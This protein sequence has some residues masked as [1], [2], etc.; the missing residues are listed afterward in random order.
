M[1]QINVKVGET[2]SV[3]QLPQ[4]LR[5]HYTD[6]ST[7]DIPIDWDMEKLNAID[8][9]KEGTYTV[10]GQAAVK[11]Y[12]FPSIHDR[13][14]PAAIKFD[15]KYYFIATRDNGQQTVL[16]WVFSRYLRRFWPMQP[17]FLLST[18]DGTDYKGFGHPNCM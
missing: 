12:P 11:D 16:T 8:W 7:G 3:N 2:V 4:T 5:A 15:G 13:A 17:R 1:E 18:S 6:T 14:D 10:T 9:D